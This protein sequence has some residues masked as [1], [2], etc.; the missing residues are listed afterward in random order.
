MKNYLLILLS[1]SCLVFASCKKKETTK[2][3][4]NNPAFI[5]SFRL[6]HNGV[7]YSTNSPAVSANNS[8][9]GVNAGTLGETGNYYQLGVKRNLL[10]GTYEYTGSI[11]DAALFMIISDQLVFSENHG[12]ITILSNDTVSRKMEFNFE[13][14][15][16]EDNTH[17]DTIRI[18]EGHAKVSY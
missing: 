17:S 18:T 11:D 3:D 6:K 8:W 9:I 12:S 2:S 5:N 14:E 7:F 15:M 13:F 10:P 4:E 1:I 16:L